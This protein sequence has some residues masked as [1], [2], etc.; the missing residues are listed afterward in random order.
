MHSFYEK[1]SQWWHVEILKKQL[2]LALA[3]YIQDWSNR[4]III[5]NT[6]QILH[7]SVLTMNSECNRW[8]EIKNWVFQVLHSKWIV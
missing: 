6:D 2:H 8:K 1:W 7:F 3:L 5:M 4:Y